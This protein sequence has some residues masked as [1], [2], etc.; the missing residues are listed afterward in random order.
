MFIIRIQISYIIIKIIFH[1]N[2]RKNK[3]I[4]RIFYTHVNI[5]YKYEKVNFK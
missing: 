5:Y 1:K 3:V 2:F 4:L